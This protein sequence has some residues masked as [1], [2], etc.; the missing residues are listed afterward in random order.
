M[1]GDLSVLP[2]DCRSEVILLDT[3]PGILYGSGNMPTTMRI[4]GHSQTS[5]IKVVWLLRLR[6]DSHT[7]KD[8]GKHDI[9]GNVKFKKP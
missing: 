6:L 9:F 2:P 1:K 8:R 3:L 7:S 5:A 4:L